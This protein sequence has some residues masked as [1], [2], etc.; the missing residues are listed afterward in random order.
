[1]WTPFVVFI[2]RV[3]ELF[4]GLIYKRMGQCANRIKMKKQGRF[5]VHKAPILY[6]GRD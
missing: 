3:Y 6:F 2:E 4:Y 1:M 5:V